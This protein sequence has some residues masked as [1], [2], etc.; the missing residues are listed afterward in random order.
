MKLS[1]H[2]PNDYQQDNGCCSQQA[3]VESETFT[4]LAAS[5]FLIKKKKNAENAGMFGENPYF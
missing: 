5:N 4:A 2:L 1:F 3:K